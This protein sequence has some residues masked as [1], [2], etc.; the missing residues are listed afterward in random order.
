MHSLNNWLFSFK[1]TYHLNTKKMIM[2]MLQLTKQISWIL[3]FVWCTLSNCTLFKKTNV[4][5]F[6]LSLLAFAKPNTAQL[7]LELV[8]WIAEESNYGHMDTFIVICLLEQHLLQGSRV[9]ND[10][11]DYLSS[12]TGKYCNK[13]ETENC[14]LYRKECN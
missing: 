14:F 2:L 5:T 10:L 7:L 1:L 6:P 8:F 11:T 9:C 12:V 3:C 13:R 4:I